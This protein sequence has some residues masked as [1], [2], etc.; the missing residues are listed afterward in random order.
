M[1]NMSIYYELLLKIGTL[2]YYIP[3]LF[4][5]F[6]LIKNK[7]YTSFEWLLFF[8]ILYNGILIFIEQFILIGNVNNFNPIY[9][10]VTI[11]DFFT[12]VAIFS[13]ILKD[14]GQKSLKFLNYIIV[15]YILAN[16]TELMFFSD[17]FSIN[18]FS[19]N[20]SKTL[21]IILSIITIYF[22]E[23]NIKFISSQ[24]IFTY[25]ILFYS[26]LTLPISLFEE[27]IRL[28]PN[29]VFFIL[30]SLNILIAI[31]FNLFITL[32]LWKLKK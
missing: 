31:F 24:K 17:F 12:I 15:I 21:I 29:S 19:N 1:N 13:N 10:T 5:L 18:L 23:I 8:F 3:F 7:S 11:I 27:Y 6:L 9:N 22:S 14:A 32:S 2:S 28:E 4:V 26:I 16:V 25:S 30:W 20:L